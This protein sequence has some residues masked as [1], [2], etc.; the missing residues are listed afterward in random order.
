M[1]DDLAVRLVR[2]EHSDAGPSDSLGIPSETNIEFERP[3]ARGDQS[4]YVQSLEAHTSCIRENAS[5]QK[6]RE[7]RLPPVCSMFSPGEVVWDKTG[8]LSILATGPKHV[9]PSYI[10]TWTDGSTTFDSATLM[11]AI[12]RPGVQTKIQ[13]IVEFMELIPGDN[14]PWYLIFMNLVVLKE[15]YDAFLGSL[16]GLSENKGGFFTRKEIANQSVWKPGADAFCDWVD[17]LLNSIL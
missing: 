14:H 2:L 16:K 5:K 4:E 12:S 8:F 3:K 11:D 13:N 15:S 10:Q 17:R 9:V 1:E 7:L 6:S